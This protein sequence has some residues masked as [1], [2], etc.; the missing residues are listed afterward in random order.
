ME[1]HFEKTERT[2]I[3]LILGSAGGL[4]LFILLCWGGFRFYRQWQE[5]RLVRRA[6]AIMSGGDLKAAG[7]TIR[8]A[9]QLNPDNPEATRLLAEMAE[10]TGDRAALDLRRKVLEL[11]PGSFDDAIALVR[12]ALRF[13]ELKV[14]EQTLQALAA[15]A[16]E[17]AEFHA[18][19]GRLAEI[20]KDLAKAE[21]HWVRAAELAP[22]DAAYRFQLAVT[23][24]SLNYQAKREKAL[25]SLEELRAEE[26]QRTAATRTLIID[27]ITQR[28]DAQ[29]LRAL[30]QDLQG[31]P[32]AAFTDRLLYLEILRQ[33]RDP[34]YSEYL[35]QVR[36]IASSKPLDMAALLSWMVRNRMHA[37]AMEIAASLPEETR[38]AWPVPLV[39]A[40]ARVGTRDWIEL[41]KF[42]RETNWE[43]YDFLRRAY[44][45]RAFREQGKQLAAEQELSAAQKEAGANPQMVSMLTQTI[46]DFGWQEEAIELVWALTKNPETRM[47]ALRTL[48]VH[49][50]KAGDTS[51]LFRTL[52]KLTEINPG[53]VALQNNLAQVSLLIGADVDRARKV[54]SEVAAKEPNN[55]AYVSTYAFALLSRGDVKGAVQAIEKLP[56][57]Q[58]QEPSVATYYG[59]I[60]SAAGEKERA[61]EF[62]QRSARAMLLPEEK[63]LVA[64][65]ESTLQ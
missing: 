49:Y 52:T 39:L 14:A 64:K 45:S 3:R 48:Y 26:S 51:G 62:L 56:Q 20:K 40:E 59:L 29:R 35:A 43:R 9:L 38:N 23:R 2:Y 8:R 36:A 37:E 50:T 24:L 34:G 11:K 58:L 63:A 6:A 60:L 46:A 4:L 53:D 47:T 13:N 28:A 57:E 41:E 12:S 17:R 61:R 55:P 21:E 10:K 42:T 32:D 15:T 65:A 25:S 19:S 18:A 7:L 22:N 27:G 1:T 54:A 30:A 44:L 33:L 5:D 16:S 31:Y